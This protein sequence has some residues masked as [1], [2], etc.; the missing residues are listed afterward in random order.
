[1]SSSQKDVKCTNETLKAAGYRAVT[2]EWCCT[3]AADPQGLTLGRTP[4]RGSQRCCQRCPTGNLLQK[5]GPAILE[6]LQP[7]QAHTWSLYQTKVR[8]V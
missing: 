6:L 2:G 7:D 3:A 5:G 8:H 4:P 1:M